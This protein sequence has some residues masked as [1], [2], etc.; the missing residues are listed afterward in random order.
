MSEQHRENFWAGLG[1]VV[2]V[3]AVYA[4]WVMQ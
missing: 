3:W 4:A 2:V 1:Y